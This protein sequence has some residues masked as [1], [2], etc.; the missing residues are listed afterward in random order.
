MS[1]DFRMGLRSL[2]E[3][4]RD[5]ALATTRPF[6][7]W[8]QGDLIRV[9][10]AILETDSGPLAHWFDG[11]AMAHRFRISEGTVHY[12]SRL[13]QSPAYTAMRESHRP[14][15]NEFLTVPDRSLWEKFLVTLRPATAS[16]H[17]GLVSVLAL[18]GT[19]VAQTEEPGGPRLDPDT[20]DTVGVLVNPDRLGGLMDTAHPLND[21][22]RNCI[23][24][25]LT[26]VSM[27]G[28]LHYVPYRIDNGSLVRQQLARHRTDRLSYLHSFGASDNYVVIA[29]WPFV[30]SFFRLATMALTSRPYGR[31]FQW[32]PELGTR[33]LVFHKDS[34]ELIGP[35]ETDPA[36]SFHHANAYED[37]SEL[38]VDV[39]VYDDV[40]IVDAL[41]LSTLGQPGGGNLPFS[42]LRRYRINLRDRTV[43]HTDIETEAMYEMPQLN[44][45]RRGFPCQ[46]LYGYSFP[47]AGTVDQ[48]INQVVKIDAETGSSTTWHQDG[49]FPGEPVFVGRP[50]S[51]RDD[52]GVLL[53][54]VLD[55]RAGR[56]EL[57]V[58]DAGTLQE[59]SRA[60]LPFVVPYEFHGRFYPA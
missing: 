48:F 11:Y 49:C 17:N 32:K 28:P 6:P 5:L 54:V 51:D 39:A 14:R 23:W 7:D 16:G 12:T 1:A 59:I 29:E 13:V 42:W 25:V 38:V 46:T 26:Q 56:S 37:G 30:S 4:V 2:R 18:D 27:L 55:T 31:N 58:L 33:F 45:R 40:Q 36:F 19:I 60:R 35:I 22:R 15:Y 57:L 24:N 3:Q 9:G 43:T 10:G 41:Q 21:A 53:S 8:L 44:P 50:G 47:R 52:D 20:L 34:G